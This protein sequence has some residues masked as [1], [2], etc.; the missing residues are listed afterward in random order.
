MDVPL[1]PAVPDSDLLPVSRPVH[2]EMAQC[3]TF[4]N[5]HAV[6]FYSD[7]HIGT[8]GPGT[9]LLFR[10]FFSHDYDVKG[11]GGPEIADGHLM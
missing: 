7:L 9:Q 4:K 3:A 5:L 6:G 10:V 1:V 8:A 11:L 2:L